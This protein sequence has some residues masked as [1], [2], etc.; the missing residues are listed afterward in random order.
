VYVGA[1]VVSTGAL[2]VDGAV[3]V[4]VSTSGV[5]VAELADELAD[6]AGVTDAADPELAPRL[7]DLCPTEPW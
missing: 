7:V 5:C 6:A 2:S 1:D 4:V 3:T